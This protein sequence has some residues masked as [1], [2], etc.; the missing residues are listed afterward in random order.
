MDQLELAE[1]IA[2]K[3]HKNQKRWNGDPYITHPERIVQKLTEHHYGGAEK[4]VAWLH[5]VLEDSEWTSSDLVNAGVSEHIIIAVLAI[6]HGKNENYVQYIK[7]VRKHE[8][9]RIVKIYDLQDNLIDLTQQQR[10][11]KYQLA[12]NMLNFGELNEFIEPNIP[13]DM[14]ISGYTGEIIYI[15]EEGN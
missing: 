12:L 8:I 7:R 1:H 6:T 11:D 10:I 14:L 5:D 4:C 3:A 9:A 13:P 2:R 15:E